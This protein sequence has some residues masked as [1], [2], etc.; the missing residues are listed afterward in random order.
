LSIVCGSLLPLGLVLDWGPNNDKWQAFE[1]LEKSFRAAGEHLPAQLLADAGYD[2]DWLHGVCREVWGV[3]SS[4]KPVVHRS[5][6][7]LGGAIGRR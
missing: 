4:V 7:S 3:Q 2:A 6:G 5:D 1:L